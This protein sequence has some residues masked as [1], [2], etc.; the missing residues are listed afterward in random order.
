MKKY[1][2]KISLLAITAMLLTGMTAC[3]NSPSSSNTQSDDSA[4]AQGSSQTAE[5]K[6]SKITVE[7]YDRS[8]TPEGGGSITDNYLTQYIADNFTKETNIEV[9]FVPIPRSSDADKLQVLMAGNS[10][11]DI[12]FLYQRDRFF[13]YAM[14]GGLTEITDDMLSQYAPDLVEFLGEDTMSYGKYDDKYYAIAAK[15]V[16]TNEHCSYIR[17]DLVEAVGMEMPTTVE[18]FY[19]VLKAI[20]EQDPAGVGSEN[21]VP[22]GMHGNTTGTAAMNYYQL[23]HAFIDPNMSEEDLYVL[24]VELY[25]GAKEG[26]RFMNKMYNEGMI[27]KDFALDDSAKQFNEDIIMGRT[28]FFSEDA[29]KPLGLSSSSVLLNLQQNYP[30][31]TLVPIDT[32]MNSAGEYRKTMYAPVDKY[33]MIPKNSEEVAPQALQYLNWLSQNLVA[34]KYGEEGVHY[35]MTDGIPVPKTDEEGLKRRDQDLWKANDTAIVVN[36]NYVGTEEE[37]LEAYANTFGPQKE[38]AIMCY[39]Q[40]MNDAYSR[41]MFDQPIESES[42][43]GANLSKALQELVVKSIMCAPEEFDATFDSLEQEYYKAGGEKVIEEKRAAY[44]EMKK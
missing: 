8:D 20:Q 10:A 14:N 22:Y 16:L 2:K 21:V 13:N 29:T 9:E 33:I 11:P 43:Y 24:P 40:G 37:N 28:V 34:I 17:Q 35:D 44:Q 32:F 12:C 5:N 23:I 31:A 7:I 39:E 36:G 1:V 42:K 4:S 19:N 3:G 27:S 15:R 25:P 6:P 18:E 26:F 30:D 38:L 41:P